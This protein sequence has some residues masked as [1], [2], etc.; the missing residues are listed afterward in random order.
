MAAILSGDADII[1]LSDT[2]MVSNKG[3]SSSQRIKN[4]L[5]DSGAKKKYEIFFNSSS[6]SRGVAVLV[7]RKLDTF[8]LNFEHRDTN[9]NFI[10]LECSI[11]RL[12]Y[13]LGAIYG[14]N[15]TSMNFYHELSSVIHTVKTKGIENII[16]GGRLE[17]HMGQ[18]YRN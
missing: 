8:A 10:I 11:D 9:E 2:R 6:N 7:N 18:E 1:F 15:T 14:P 17:R 5:R 12:N 3:I 13:A 4:S 16:L